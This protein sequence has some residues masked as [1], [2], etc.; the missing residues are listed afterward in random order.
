VEQIIIIGCGQ[1]AGV[2]LYN[3]ETQGKYEA[4]GYFDS[5]ESK[6]GLERNGLRVLDS[7][8]SHDMEVL[9]TKYGTDKFFVGFG[10]MK[11]RKVVYEKFV[12]A[13]WEPINI[14]HPGAVISKHA[15][16]GKGVLIEA[17]CLI[18]SNPIIGNNVVVNTGSQVNHDNIVGDHVY[19][20]S[21][22]ILSGGVTI[23]GNSLIDDG[24]VI[25]LGTKVGANCIIGAG[26]VVTKD[27]P[28]NTVAYGIPA[29]V[30]RGND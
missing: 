29:R 7:Y 5:D 2:V 14:F 12:S 19:I 22:V 16:I 20:A 26:S 17:G 18:T 27:I 11:H 28:D 3:L 8:T 4:L 21:G 23:E 6:V 15:Q 1:H 30:V 13:G 24:V 25:T 9:K 10:N